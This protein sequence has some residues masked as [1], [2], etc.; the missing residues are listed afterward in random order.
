MRSNTLLYLHSTSL[1]H[2]F[3]I[4]LRV[5]QSKRNLHLAPFVGFLGSTNLLKCVSFSHFLAKG[6]IGKDTSNHII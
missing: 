3:I 1:K 5:G 2:Y 6:E 4:T